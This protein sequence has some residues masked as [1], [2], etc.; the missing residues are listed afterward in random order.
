MRKVISLDEFEEPV[1]RFLE[2]LEVSNEASVIEVGNKNVYLVVRPASEPIDEPWTDAKNR[3]R[4]E[5]IDREIASTLTPDET[6]ELQQ[7]TQAMRRHR[8]RVAPL[9]FNNVRQLH[10]QLL[11]EAEKAMTN[12]SGDSG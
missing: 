5:L 9:P 6:V 3:R 12:G 1:R 7:L 10:E 2:R 11:R 8:D 4:Y